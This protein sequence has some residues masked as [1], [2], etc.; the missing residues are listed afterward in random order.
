MARDDTFRTAT[1]QTGMDAYQFEAAAIAN[2]QREL[3]ARFQRLRAVV[4]AE[5]PELIRARTDFMMAGADKAEHFSHYL[6][7]EEAEVKYLRG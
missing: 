3:D 5:S 7:G 1:G 2:A 4:A 6:R